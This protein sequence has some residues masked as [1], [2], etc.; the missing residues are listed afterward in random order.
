M[1]CFLHCSM[2]EISSWRLLLHMAYMVM[3]CVIRYYSVWKIIWIELIK[4]YIKFSLM[5]VLGPT[6]SQTASSLT[7]PPPPP[8]QLQWYSDS[9]RPKLMQKCLAYYNFYNCFYVAYL[10]AVTLDSIWYH[11][12]LVLVVT[13]PNYIATCT[14]DHPCSKLNTMTTMLP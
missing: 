4:L 14:I 13:W 10:H 11:C 3:A 6:K 5:W 12:I 2:L 9:V 8:L 1:T 7:P